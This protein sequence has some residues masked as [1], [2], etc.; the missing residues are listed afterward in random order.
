MYN[1]YQ[2]AY[3]QPQQQAQ[4][5][6]FVNVRSEIEA[7]NYPIVPGTSV[8]FK[9]ENEPYIY[10]K[11]IISQLDMPTFEKYRLVKEDAQETQTPDISAE[12]EEIR[13]RL[14]ALEKPKSRKKEVVADE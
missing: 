9:N 6:G 8:I 5:T 11:T 12:L 3:V 10:T 1:P 13:N 7:R 2:M 14:D 4:Q